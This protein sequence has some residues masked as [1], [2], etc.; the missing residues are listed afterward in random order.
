MLNIIYL[1][2]KAFNSQQRHWQCGSILCR[3]KGQSLRAKL[4]TKMTYLKAVG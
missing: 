4:E 3:E 2:V 1:I